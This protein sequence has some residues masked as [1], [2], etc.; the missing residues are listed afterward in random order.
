MIEG[1]LPA[2]HP[3]PAP[4]IHD[5]HDE[6]FVL[7]EGRMRFRL[8][9]GYRTA[10][11]GDTVFAGRGLAHGSANRARSPDRRHRTDAR[12]GLDGVAHGSVFNAAGAGSGRYRPGLIT[13]S[14]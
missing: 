1:V 14:T 13:R 11:A 2:G 9:A 7:L 5:G 4:H 3:G 10:A 6:C 12:P 8:D